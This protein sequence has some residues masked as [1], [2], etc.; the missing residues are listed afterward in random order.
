MTKIKPLPF[1]KQLKCN[2]CNTNK[3]LSRN[4]ETTCE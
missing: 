3:H 2:P 4:W 1:G